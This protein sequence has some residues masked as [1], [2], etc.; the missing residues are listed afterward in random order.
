MKKIIVFILMSLVCSI[1]TEAKTT[2]IPKYFS[3]IDIESATKLQSDSSILRELTLMADD[4]RYAITIMHDS[5]TKERVKAIKRMKAAAGWAGVSAVLSGVSAGLQP[6]HTGMD[7]VMYM[8]KMGN[9]V[10]STSLSAFASEEASSLEKVPVNIN[11]ENLTDRE[12][13]V[14]D[15]NRGLTWFIRPHTYLNLTVGNPEVN[16]LRIAY[17]DNGEQKVDYLTLMA[18]NQLTKKN[19]AYEDEDIW[20]IPLYRHGHDYNPTDYRVINKITF[21]AEEIKSEEF[22]QYKK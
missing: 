9:M 11:I 3:R 16:S 12:M 19:I 6:L 10:A 7:A 20:I 1:L 17:A 2:Y 8:N 18:G 21:E 13:V 22:K 15:L 4:N 14:N 5:V